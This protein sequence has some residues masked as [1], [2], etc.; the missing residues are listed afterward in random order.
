MVIKKFLVS[1]SIF[2]LTVSKSVFSSQILDYETEEFIKSI[3]YEIKSV[4]KINNDINF[5]ILSNDEINAFVTEDNT[6]HITAGLIKNSNDYVALFSV[7]AHEIGHIEKKHI[8]QRK[9]SLKNINNLS[10]LSNLSIIAGS[11][12]YGNPEL[13][14]GSI[15]NSAS[16]SNL[17]INFN[18]DQEREADFYSIKTLERAQLYSNSIVSLLKTIEKKALE[19]GLNKDLQRFSSH[20]KFEDRINIINFLK[21][22]KK[23][24]FNIQTDEKFNL[25]KAKFIGYGGNDEL[26]NKLKAPYSIYANSILDAKKGKL[27]DSLKKINLLISNNQ[28]NIYLLETKADILFSYGYT[29]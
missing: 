20:P 3:I 10:K 15:I 27:S 17:I 23:N 29:N 14:Q 6:I 8:K 11:M 2:I 28:D 25:I 26:I 22:N 4:N 13:L 5:K 7:I 24:N 18:Q 9:K 16:V 1:L 21:K 12:V 19:K